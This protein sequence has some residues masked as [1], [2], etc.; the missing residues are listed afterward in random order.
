M[1][2]L[3]EGFEQLFSTRVA[4]VMFDNADGTS[5]QQILK[6]CHP[7][8][9]VKLVREPNNPHDKSAIAV[10]TTGGKQIGYMPSDPRLAQHMDMGGAVSAIILKITG[11]PGFFGRL[12]PFIRKSYGC[13]L[14]VTKRDPDWSE[15]AEPLEKNREIDRIVKEARAKE[16]DTPQE[17][18]KDYLQAIELIHEL[19]EGSE[20][21]RACR[22]VRY[23]INRLSVMLDRAG[24]AERA[25][26]EIERYLAYQDHIG[27]SNSDLTGIT[28]RLERLKRK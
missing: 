16:T 25:I 22:T 6:K 4:G 20:R 2:I 26:R 13:V 28:R 11:G 7:R 17:A 24:D 19:D 10:F 8:Q 9:S 1:E 23:P 5:R 15:L 27:I 12:F 21:A 14:E 3:E 18:I